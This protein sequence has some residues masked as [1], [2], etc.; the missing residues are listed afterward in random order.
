VARASSLDAQRELF[1]VSLYARLLVFIALCAVSTPL[2]FLLADDYP[3]STILF[4]LATSVF[5]GHWS[6]PAS[7]DQ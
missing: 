3:W 6:T 4:M 7:G 1:R 5:R 2:T